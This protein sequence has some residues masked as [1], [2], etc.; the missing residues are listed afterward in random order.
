MQTDRISRDRKRS[1]IRMN[2]LL[3]SVMVPTKSPYTLELPVQL[4]GRVESYL[5]TDQILEQGCWHH[6]IRFDVVN[7]TCRT[8]ETSTLVCEEHPQTSTVG[9]R[10]T[11]ERFA[12]QM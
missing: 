12:R 7:G 8:L 6:S 3:K 1:I 5:L 10:W 4:L 9:P 2:T 11:A